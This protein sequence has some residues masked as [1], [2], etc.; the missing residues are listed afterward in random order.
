MRKLIILLIPIIILFSG[1]TKDGS[2]VIK[3]ADK[4]QI[5]S[6]LKEFAGINGYTVSYSDENKGL[7]RVNTGNVQT[8]QSINSNYHYTNNNLSGSTY[9]Q[10]PSSRTL[11]FIAQISQNNNNV[12]LTYNFNNFS[13]WFSSFYKAGKFFDYLENNGYIISKANK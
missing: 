8:G 12:I 10:P 6:L 13:N 9:V 3:N 4:E 1:C 7:Y 2:I 5:I 11:Y